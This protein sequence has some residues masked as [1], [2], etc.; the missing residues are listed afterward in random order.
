MVGSIW[1]GD[2]YSQEIEPTLYHYNLIY[3]SSLLGFFFFFYFKLI[4]FFTH[5]GLV[6]LSIMEWAVLVSDVHG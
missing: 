4:L 5:P 1:A 2:T 6:G 3:R